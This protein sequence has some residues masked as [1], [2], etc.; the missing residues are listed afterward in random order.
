MGY[1]PLHCD[2]NL[3]S[4]LQLVMTKSEFTSLYNVYHKVFATEL[5]KKLLALFVSIKEK[6]FATFLHN[7]LLQYSTARTGWRL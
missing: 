4:F 6:P 5:Q 7:Y 1:Y 2:C 3:S